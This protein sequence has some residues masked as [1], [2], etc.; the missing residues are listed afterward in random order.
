MYHSVTFVTRGSWHPT[1]PFPNNTYVNTWDEWH[2]IPT[3][4]PVIAPPEAETSYEE[5]AI[6]DG[7]FDLTDI[8]TDVLMLPPKPKYGY[9]EGSIKFRVENGFANWPDLYSDI[10][11]ILHGQYV[12]IIL[13]DDPLYY[14]EGRVFVDNWESDQHCSFVTIGYKL[15]PTKSVIE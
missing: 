3:A 10:A 5:S 4:R 15:H 13:E 14:Y 8:L 6:S 1:R 2:L 9:R 7:V 11:D 12:R